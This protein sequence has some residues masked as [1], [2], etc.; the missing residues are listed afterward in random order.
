MMLAFATAT[1]FYN[2]DDRHQIDFVAVAAHAVTLSD[3]LSMQG[4]RV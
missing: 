2:H 3:W 1:S 4:L